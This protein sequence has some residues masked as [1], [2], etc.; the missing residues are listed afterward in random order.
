MMSM[1]SVLIVQY[2]IL[3]I[4]TNK[5]YIWVYLFHAAQ[6]ILNILFGVIYGLSGDDELGVYTFDTLSDWTFWLILIC[7]IHL[8]LIPI[9]FSRYFDFLFSDTIINNLRNQRTQ[10]DFATKMYIKKIEHMTKCTR[11]LAK[12]K[13]IYKALDEYNADNFADRKMRE[14]VQLY[15]STK[16]KSPFINNF[17]NQCQLRSTITNNY[18]EK[19]RARNHN[20]EK[21]ETKQLFETEVNRKD[22]VSNFKQTNGKGLFTQDEALIT[23]SVNQSKFSI[24]NELE[25]I[26]K[27]YGSK[28]VPPQNTKT[29]VLKV[30]DPNIIEDEKIINDNSQINNLNFLCKKVEIDDDILPNL[31]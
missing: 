28:K 29:I 14:I 19:V 9:Y 13:K 22:E 8:C 3:F 21:E 4:D 6:I 11:S 17:D 31:E 25:E 16:K 24:N 18:L 30:C 5:Y 27:Y 1:L 23:E 15:K 12:F 10:N 7:C 2:V 26:N 20:I